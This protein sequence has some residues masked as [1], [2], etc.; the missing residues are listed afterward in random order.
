[1]IPPVL[2][3]VKAFEHTAHYDGMIANFLGN[4]QSFESADQFPRTFNVQMD[5][6]Q[7]LRYGE[8][9]STSRFYVEKRR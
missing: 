4:L 3:L 6:A 8:N 2:I 9:P 1:M 7:D 5:K